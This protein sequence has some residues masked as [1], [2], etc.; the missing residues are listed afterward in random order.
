M[1]LPY[2]E[3]VVPPYAEKLSI[4]YLFNLVYFRK[5][6][7]DS[8]TARIDYLYTIYIIYL[9]LLIYNIYLLYDKSNNP[10]AD[11]N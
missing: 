2:P 4:T 10:I 8:V 3:K 5:Y 9:L 7:L 11:Y 6:S 1:V